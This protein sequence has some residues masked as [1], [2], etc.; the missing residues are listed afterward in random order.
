M[1]MIAPDDAYWMGQA[2]ACARQAQAQGEVPVGAVLVSKKNTLIA[3]GYNQPILTNDPCAHAEIVTLRAAGQVLG[4][5]RLIDSTLYV[6]LEPCAMCA[7]ACVHARIGR[8]VYAASDPKRGACGSALDVLSHPSVNHVVTL[9]HGV[10]A[11]ECSG[12]LQQFF[13]SK[14]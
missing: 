8:L 6:T 9:H 11:A 12:L 5:Y 7:G 14:R 13:K 4:N 10:M 3:T 2:F 1:G